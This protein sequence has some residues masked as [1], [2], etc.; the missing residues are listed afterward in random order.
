MPV[1]KIQTNQEV[2]SADRAQMLTD[3]SAIV[4]DMLGKPERYV[5][6]VFEQN[7]DMRFANS[8][9]PL[10]YLELKSIGLPIDKTTGFSAIL[11]QF[12]HAY[13]NIPADRIY[14]EFSDAQRQM[15]GWNGDTF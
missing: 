10:A 6:V 13:L 11:S 5:M 4:A 3:A 1:L 2:N 14:I 7:I 9:K 12:I 8:D 15:W